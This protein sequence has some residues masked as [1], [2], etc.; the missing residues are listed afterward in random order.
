ML[1]F[2]WRLPQPRATISLIVRPKP[3]S[4]FAWPSGLSTVSPVPQSSRGIFMSKKIH[5]QNL[6]SDKIVDLLAQADIHVT[7]LNRA[8]S[9]APRFSPR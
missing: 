7:G 3:S 6:T 9:F 5:S 1:G 4:K 8:E 2:L